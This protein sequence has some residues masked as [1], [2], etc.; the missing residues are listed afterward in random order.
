MT[1][2]QRCHLTFFSAILLVGLLSPAAAQT[3][4]STSTPAAQP[5]SSQPSQAYTLPPDKLAKAIA[6]NRVRNILDIGGSIWAF[7][8]LGLFLATG[9]ASSLESRAIRITTRR[10]LQGIIFFAAF[11]FL[12]TLA[13]LPLYCVGH[14]YSLAYGISVQRWGSFFWDQTKSFAVTLLLLTP[15]FL[16]F[17][18]IV[19]RWPRRYWFGVW[20]ATLPLLVFLLFISPLL[21]PIFNEFEPLSQN[22]PS[23]VQDLER[24][25]A[26][27]GTAIPPERMF[28]M[29]ASAKTN[30]L[31]AYVNGLGATK[32]I[33][34][35]DTT[36]GRISNDEV[37]FIFGHESGHYVLNH[38]PKL[39]AGSAVGLFIVYWACAQFAAWASH[40]Y[41]RGWLLLGNESVIAPLGTRAGFIILLF[42]FA[43]AN[44]IATP[45][46]NTFSRY[47]EHQADVYGQEAM[48]GL[49]PNPQKT[50]VDAF[51]ALGVAWLEDPNPSPFIE[52]WD[53]DHPSL[54]TRA[55]FAS[56]YD[57]WANG[58]HGEFFDK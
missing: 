11:I 54:K 3:A 23:L 8:F 49:V 24:V 15:I 55:N 35:W 16:L 2:A 50:A 34:V 37:L 44:F 28:L 7:V 42:A 29:K 52:F 43:L 45:V 14:Y 6:L 25:V 22:N 57:P 32:R 36:A 47:F 48:H 10:W 17:N 20:V 51:D 19:C 41:G 1:F 18:W 4:P 12:T 58:G 26:R 5:S 9:A 13:A 53:Y 31:N 46:S 56:Q 21:E 39:L 30:G 27:T 33:V 38:L 40:R